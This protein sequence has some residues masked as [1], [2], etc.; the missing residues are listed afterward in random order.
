MKKIYVTPTLEV[1]EYIPE[2]Q[3]LDLSN[4]KVELNNKEELGDD[5]GE[6]FGWSNKRQPNA[7][8]GKSPWE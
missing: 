5:D 2:G 8:W 1:F 7:N 6:N 3:L 4:I